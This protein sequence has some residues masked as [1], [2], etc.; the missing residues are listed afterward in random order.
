MG[1]LLNGTIHFSRILQL[2]NRIK[3]LIWLDSL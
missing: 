2:R 1:E 3:N